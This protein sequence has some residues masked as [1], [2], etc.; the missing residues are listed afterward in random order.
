MSDP[1]AKKC[2]KCGAEG[3][4]PFP[5]DI[6]SGS[7]TS[8]GF[9]QESSGRVHNICRACESAERSKRNEERQARLNSEYTSLKPEDFDVTVANEP[10]K[11]DKEAAAQKRQEYNARM[12]EFADALHTSGGDPDLISPELGTYVARLSEQERRFGNRRIARSV[13]LLAAHEALQLRQL[14]ELC[15]E[16]LADRVTPTGYAT[17]KPEGFRPKRTVVQGLSDLHLGSELCPRDNPRP[18]TAIEEARRLEYLLRQAMDYKPQYREDSDFLLILDGDLAEG[19]LL[20]D[21]RDGVPLAEQKIIFW[22]HF[23][24][25]I[26]YLASAYKRVKVVCEPGNHGRDIVRHPGRATSRKWDGHE[27]EMYYALSM[28]CS[29]LLNVEWDIPFKAVATVDLH[30]SKGLV[31]HGDTELKLGDPD[32]KASANAAT[33]DRINSTRIYGV[34]Y[35][36]AFFGHYHK[37]RYIPGRVRTLWNGALVP[38][39]GHAR[40]QGY[41]N[42]VCGQWLWEATEGH[43]VGDARFIEVGPMQD[44]DERLG[45]LI[46]PF[47]FDQAAAA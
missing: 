42:E 47:R 25:Y 37:P 23:R 10:S 29:S 6:T 31:S 8:S 24:L 9:R 32:T 21:L 36:W 4:S 5:D 39:N 27:W 46:P 22:R 1:Q 3:G 14:R 30:G 17:M 16:Y 35:D 19:Y 38:P 28:M 45:G 26:G 33:L 40:G 15:S 13:S 18:F 43:P 41:I 44:H 11:N 7:S 34:E 20:H 12:G 2:R